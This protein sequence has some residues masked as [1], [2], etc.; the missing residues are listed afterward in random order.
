VKL[1]AEGVIKKTPYFIQLPITQLAKF[2]TGKKNTT[3][4]QN[5]TKQRRN[6]KNHQR[7]CSQIPTGAHKNM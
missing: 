6:C 4:K 1:E 3:N 7:E 2:S 5:P